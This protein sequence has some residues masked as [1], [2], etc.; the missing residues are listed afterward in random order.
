M[1]RWSIS[2][3]LAPLLCI[4]LV[5]P[6]AQAAFHLWTFSEFFSSAD[7]S[8][9]FI[10]MFTTSSSETA[11]TGAQIRTTSENHVFSF[12]S[13]TLPST[14]NKHIL[15]ATSGFSPLAGS[16]TPD[17]VLD[18]PKFFDPAGDTVR[19]FHPFFGE[20]HAKMFG[21]LPS[22]GVQSLN[23]PPPAGTA[24]TNTPTNFV[25][26]KGEVNL[27]PPPQTTGDYNLDGTVNAADYTVWRDTFG[28]DVED[29]TGADGF[30]DGTIDEQDYSF[31]KSHFGE[32]VDQPG[33]GAASILVPEPAVLALASSG[34]FAFLFA[35]FRTRTAR[36]LDP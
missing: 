34:I 33:G 15:L 4:A 36:R 6:P 24:L 23:Y 7:G 21:A 11:A 28:Q 5:A 16:V 27:S 20:F 12:P 25:G 19:I 26:A 13:V 3:L 10:E 8:V 29:G 30:A 35:A 1:R 32:E 14:T 9:Q 18:I 17:Y 22:D 31:W 2:V